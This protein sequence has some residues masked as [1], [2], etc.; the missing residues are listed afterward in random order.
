[1][2]CSAKVSYILLRYYKYVAQLLIDFEMETMLM[3]KMDLNQPA[4]KE[5]LFTKDFSLIMVAGM[6]AAFMN[7]LF[8]PALALHMVDVVGG[9]SVHVGFAALAFS[10]TALISRPICGTLSDK[11][12]RTPQLI[13]GTAICAIACI[14]YGITTVVPVLIAIRALT[15]VGFG[16]FS[17]CAG[18]VAADVSPKSR[19]SEGI[20]IYGLGATLAQAVGPGLAFF[21]IGAG[22]HADFRNLF[23]ISAGMCV[24]SAIASSGI[25]YERKRKKAEKLAEEAS[26]KTSETSSAGNAVQPIDTKELPKTIIGFEYAALPIIATLIL[27]FSGVSGLFFYLP[28]LSREA[29]FGN[30][31]FY[32]VLSATG[33]FLSRMLMGRVV[34]KRGADFIMIPG[35]IALMTGYFLIPFANSLTMLVLMG[36]PIGFAHGSINPIFNTL[37][38]RRC[39][40]ARRGSASGAFFA[41]IDIGF[42]LGPLVLGLLADAYDLRFVFWG[43]ATMMAL[44]FVLYLLIAS[45]KPFIKYF[46][47]FVKI[48]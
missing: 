26:E 39:S 14:L 35:L 46:E 31:T 5:R 16:M 15:G 19:L 17:T 1:M 30:P 42:G 44:G 13:I 41:A 4:A 12:G 27:I 20:G 21:I 38:F 25:G 48:D 43:G 6:G 24:I 34:D 40:A 23:F 36:L 47:K 7:H 29:G 3:T 28:A 10:I 11:Y 33:M 8:A 22:T 9:L 45:E 2:L 37:L 32:F 18:A